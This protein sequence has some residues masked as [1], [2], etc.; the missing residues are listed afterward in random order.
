M[1]KIKFS[2]HTMGTPKLDIYQAMTLFKEIGY[3]GIEVRVAANGQIDSEKIS[4]SEAKK[5][6]NESKPINMEFSCLTSYYKDFVSPEAR[7]TVIK[8]LKRVIEIADILQCPLIRLYG[9]MDPSPTG[10]SFTENWSRTVSGI[11]EVAGFAAKFGTG[12]CVET[13]IGSLTVSVR[14]TVRLIKDVNM[15]NVGILFDYAWVD[16]ANVEDPLEAVKKAAR[17]IFHCHVKDWMMESRIPLKKKSRLM[18]KGTLDWKKVLPEI[19]KTGYNGYISDE[20]EK[21]WYPEE[22]PEPEVGMKHNLEYIK[23]LIQN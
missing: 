19:G 10:I 4:N 18:G 22:L 7:G 8:N 3:D 11:Q 17:Y 16:Y 14:D 23:K 21:F 13:H 6:Y 15:N 1:S 20:Y 9:G 5:I 2:G 12:I